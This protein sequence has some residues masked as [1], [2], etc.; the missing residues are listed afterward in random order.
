ML[1]KYVGGVEFI[2]IEVDINCYFKYSSYKDERRRESLR[3]ESY[4]VPPF[5]INNQS[6]ELAA[7]NP[8]HQSSVLGR[9]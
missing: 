9:L 8:K 1:S 5:Y 7:I 3:L 2:I 6:Q 4:S